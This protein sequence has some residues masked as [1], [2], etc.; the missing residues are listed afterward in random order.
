M[1]INYEK[2]IIEMTKAEAKEAGKYNSEKY[3]ELKEIR[4]VFPTFRIVTKS[5]PK[6]RDTYKGL[7]YAYMIKYIEEHTKEDDVRRTEFSQM[8]GYVNAKKLALAET[9]TYGEVK[10]WFLLKF[11]E[12]EEYNKKVEELREATRI[13]NEA[14]KAS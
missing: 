13:A 8:S 11:P 9:A 1:T 7:T 4:S 10:A 14:K 5:T 6:K 2:E 3:N 12:I